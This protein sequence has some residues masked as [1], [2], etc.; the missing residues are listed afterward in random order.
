MTLFDER[1]QG[2]KSDQ[3]ENSDTQPEK[4][5]ELRMQTLSTS[6]KRPMR[7][8]KGGGPVSF[9]G[10]RSGGAASPVEREARTDRRPKDP[11]MGKMCSVRIPPASDPAAGDDA[12]EATPNV[13]PQDPN[14]ASQSRA[15]RP[16]RTPSA[17]TPTPR[18]L[19]AAPREADSPWSEEVSRL[20]PKRSAQDAK[21]SQS[22]VLTRTFKPGKG[23]TADAEP[24][25]QFDLSPIRIPPETS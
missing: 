19:R 9:V 25:G 14:I 8:R 1:P 22:D 20:A 15:P 6:V 13:R 21:G 5:V 16:L 23:G 4:T 24:T 3:I 12:T 2:P 10:M 18:A 11:A 7:E 17:S